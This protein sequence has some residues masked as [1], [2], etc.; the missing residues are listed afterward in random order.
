MRTGR[1]GA[2][3]AS[4]RPRSSTSLGAGGRVSL[5]LSTIHIVMRTLRALQDILA[6]L[7]ST[8]EVPVAPLPLVVTTK[9][10]FEYCQMFSRGQ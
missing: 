10:V 1:R 4:P 2:R 6:C 7:A 3:K 5:H 8:H 9:D